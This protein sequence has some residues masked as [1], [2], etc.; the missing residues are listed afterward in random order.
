MDGGAIYSFGDDCTGGIW[1]HN[2][3]EDVVGSTEGSVTPS[4]SNYSVG[5]YFDQWCHDMTAA[6]NS[7]IRAGGIGM[8]V[9]LNDARITM[10][11]NLIY[12][13]GQKV[14]MVQLVQ[15]TTGTYG[16]HVF[17]GNTLYP[18]TDSA[19]FFYLV[20]EDG[21]AFVDWG[22]MGGNQY[23]NPYSS[24]TP[25]IAYGNGPGGPGWHEVALAGWQSLGGFGHDVDATDVYAH[26]AAGVRPER[27]FVNPTAAP[28]PVDL[29]AGTY[30]DLAGNPVSGPVA[31]APYT[32]LILI[33]E[34][35]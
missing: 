25:F 20:Q 4:T 35:P 34:S 11:N 28:L 12:D 9:Q 18:T 13:S 22:T 16:G 6:S 30:K 3:I 27:L 1:R 10:T 2:I 29:S 14:A 8:Y 31:L 19:T 7:V 26:F 15:H 23:C 17:T 33:Q 32:S 5:I 21:T 24:P